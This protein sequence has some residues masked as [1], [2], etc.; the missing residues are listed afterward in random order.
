MSVSSELIAPAGSFFSGDEKKIS[1]ILNLWPG[2]VSVILGTIG[3]L[4]SLFIVFEII[5]KRLRFTF[6]LSGLFGGIFGFILW[7]NILG[8]RLL[9]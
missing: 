8:P 4:I 6:I 1:V 5:P 2:T 7:M 3:L 9:P